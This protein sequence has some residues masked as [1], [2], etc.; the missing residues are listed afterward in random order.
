MGW[1][2]NQKSS[3]TWTL[4]TVSD[5]TSTAFTGLKLGDDQTLNFGLNA[6]SSIEWNNTSDKL[7]FRFLG[8]DGTIEMHKKLGSDTL[9]TLRVNGNIQATDSINIS[10]TST[11]TKWTQHYGPVFA[12]Y[13]Q[14]LGDFGCDFVCGNHTGIFFDDC[15]TSAAL[16][17]QNTNT[18]GSEGRLRVAMDDGVA[19]LYF[20]N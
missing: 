11:F 3:T 17:S 16:Q 20:A 5:L 18:S 7:T 6:D 1:I 4:N 12:T 19:N 15:P 13:M 8:T 14:P 10:G 2:A 9:A